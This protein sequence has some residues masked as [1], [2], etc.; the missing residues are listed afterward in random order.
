MP[1]I[2]PDLIVESSLREGLA[3]IRNDTSIVDDVFANLKTLPIWPKYGDKEL[4]KIKKLLSKS[5]I[6]I[7]HSFP[8]DNTKMPCFSI[9]LLPSKENERRA[10]MDDFDNDVTTPMDEE[11]LAEQVIVSSV[12]IDSYDANSGIVYI[13]D[14]INLAQ[15][16]VNHI[17]VDSNGEEFTIL[18]GVN[19]D[20]GSKKFLI[21]KQAEL[22]TSGPAVIKSSIDFKQYEVRTNVES[23]SILVGI[24]TKE[25]LQTKYLHT[26]VKY[27]IESRKKDFINRGFSQMTYEASDFTQN[28]EYASDFIYTRFLTI[29]GTLENT[30]NSDKVTPIDNLEV[31]VKVEKD[32]AG[33]EDLGLQNSTI[34]VQEDE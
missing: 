13:D 7:V 3:N 34:Q 10:V 1:F 28:Q 12:L 18:G 32:K 6:N 23:C 26:L 9:Q 11:E 19:N 29:S 30:W 24:H 2:L 31:E 4:N 17:L 25:P 5:E 22:E 8:A 14:S 15:V 16:H 20:T 33:N 27:I 21:Q